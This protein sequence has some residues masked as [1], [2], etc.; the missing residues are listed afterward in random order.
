VLTISTPYTEQ[1]PNG[2][3]QISMDIIVESNPQHLGIKAFVDDRVQ[4]SR[5]NDGGGG[6]YFAQEY[7]TKIGNSDAYVLTDINTHGNG[8]ITSIS[9][10]A[11]NNV[12]EFEIPVEG[13]LNPPGNGSISANSILHEQIQD[14]S[15]IIESFQLI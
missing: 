14:M 10:A 1:D 2:V 15:K 12:I 8:F 7:A 11:G 13:T 5:K 9:V 4:A 3:P 6:T